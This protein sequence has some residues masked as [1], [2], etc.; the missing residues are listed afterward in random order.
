MTSGL[1][2]VL[3][4]GYAP[5]DGPEFVS[6]FRSVPLAST[7]KFPRPTPRGAEPTRAVD[8]PRTSAPRT[9]SVTLIE[10]SNIMCGKRWAQV[11]LAERPETAARWSHDS[12]KQVV[13]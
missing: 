6:V 7:T 13:P 4:S 10:P 9:N 12:G 3:C 2:T 5:D 11:R 1:T 8:S